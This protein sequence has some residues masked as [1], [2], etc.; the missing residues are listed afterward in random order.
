MLKG[1]PFSSAFLSAIFVHEF[2]PS[3][4]LSAWHVA[5]VVKFHINPLLCFVH[6]QNTMLSGR[7]SSRQY[8]QIGM[9]TIAQ[10]RCLLRTS[11]VQCPKLPTH[12]KPTPAH[13]PQSGHRGPN[14]YMV[15]QQPQAPHKMG[16]S[17]LQTT[18]LS[19]QQG[20]HQLQGCGTRTKALKCSGAYARC[21]RWE[22]ELRV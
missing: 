15:Q 13:R 14:E 12:K 7:N 19:D 5:S 10:D 20:G 1:T 8:S 4:T 22:F 16:G 21:P 2:S 11:E 17:L 6:P 18:R 9:D 3:A